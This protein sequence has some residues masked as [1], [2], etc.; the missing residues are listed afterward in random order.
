MHKLLCL[1]VLEQSRQVISRISQPPAA[2]GP[3][4]AATVFDSKINHFIAFFPLQ[5]RDVFRPQASKLHPA[6][7]V[8][9]HYPCFPGTRGADVCY[10]RTRFLT[11]WTGRKWVRMLAVSRKT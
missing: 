8:Q 5:S 3:V 1:Q 2:Y 7:L 4:M 10:L 9:K 6:W 11:G